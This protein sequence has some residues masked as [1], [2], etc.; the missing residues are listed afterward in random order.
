LWSSMNTCQAFSS[1]TQHTFVIGRD[2]TYYAWG[3]NDYGQLGMGKTSGAFDEPQK[4][5]SWHPSPV[6]CFAAGVGTSTILTRDGHAYSWGYNSYGQLGQGHKENCDTPTRIC[7]DNHETDPFMQIVS[8]QYHSMGLT[9]SGKVFAWGRNEHGQVGHE[10]DDTPTPKRVPLEGTIVSLACGYGHSVALLEDGTTYLWGVNTYGQ[11]GQ[12][13]TATQK[14]PQLLSIKGSP[15][16]E[17]RVAKISCGASHTAFITKDGDFWICGRN[18]NCELGSGDTNHYYEPLK[19]DLPKRALHVACGW[20]H[21]LVIVEDGSLYGWGDNTQFQV[22]TKD[23]EN[24]RTPVQ[25]QLPFRADVDSSRRQVIQI[26]VGYKHSMAMT[27]DGSFFTWG[28]H[29]GELDHNDTRYISRVDKLALQPPLLYSQTENLFPVFLLLLDF[30][31]PGFLSNVY[32]S[33]TQ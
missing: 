23:C 9:K 30:L 15:G 28:S 17:T 18:D 12:G 32:Y 20:G 29:D 5:E 24:K 3:E 8:G 14:S 11:L 6:V 31:R 26:G 2:G 16:N 13:H 7:H 10:G 33:H 4:L 22:G 21:N 1:N 27:S 19:I 25:I